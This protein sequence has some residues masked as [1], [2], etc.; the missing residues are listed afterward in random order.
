MKNPKPIP[1][2][3]ITLI[4]ASFGYSQSTLTGR[5]VEVLDGKTV[6]IEISSGRLTAVLQYVEVP[7]PEQQL[8]GTVREHLEKLVLNKDVVFRSTGLGQGR[9]FGQLYV[10]S[11]DV[12][13]QMLRDGAAWH[14]SPEKS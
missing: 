9:T 14:I 7:E 1:V 2:L 10:N 3:I 6:V 4:F 12:A 11:A 8:H 13:V 5:V